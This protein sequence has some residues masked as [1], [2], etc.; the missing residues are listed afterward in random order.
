V[1]KLGS[2]G[3]FLFFCCSVGVSFL[4]YTEVYTEVYIKIQKIFYSHLISSSKKHLPSS[5]LVKGN[6]KPMCLLS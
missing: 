3:K 4:I 1:W 5:L 6:C 2:F